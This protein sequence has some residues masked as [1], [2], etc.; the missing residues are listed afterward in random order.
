VL[1]KLGNSLFVLSELFLESSHLVR[2]LLSNTLLNLLF[3]LRNAHLLLKLIHPVLKFSLLLLYSTN[4][5]FDV[6]KTD[7]LSHDGDFIGNELLEASLRVLGVLEKHVKLLGLDQGDDSV[8][9]FA[10]DVGLLLGLAF[11]IHDW[12]SVF[13]QVKSSELRSEGLEGG[14]DELNFSFDVFRGKIIFT[15]NW[16]I[17]DADGLSD[18]SLSVWESLEELFR[19]VWHDWVE[20]LES[21]V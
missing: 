19:Q 20:H 4:F 21:G 18:F 11:D 16:E 14:L 10:N 6:N 12:L 1:R 7:N 3:I 13:G 8:F 17:S 15:F 9:T 2:V 5:Q